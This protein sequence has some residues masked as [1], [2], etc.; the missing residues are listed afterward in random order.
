MFQ[1]DETEYKELVE[2]QSDS[3]VGG[4]S[5]TETNV[6]DGDDETCTFDAEAL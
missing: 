3:T 2:E 4:M 1:A 6:E 5:N